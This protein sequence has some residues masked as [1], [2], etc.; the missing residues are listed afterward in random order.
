MAKKFHLGWFMNFSADE[1][2]GVFASGG[3]PFS[4]RFYTEMAQDLERACFDYIMIEDTLMVSDA[5]GGSSELYLRQALMAPKHDPAPLAAVLSAA[6]TRLGVV[7]TL[8]TSFYPPFLLARLATTIDNIAE[9]RF[10]WN[11]VT[12]AEDH[13][14]RN[15]GL[16][17]IPPHARRYD[18]AEEYMEV[19]GKLF[20]SWDADAIVIDRATST[21]ADWTKVN[22][23]NHEGKFFKVRGPLNTAPSPQG[24]P[25]YVQAGGSE[26]GRDF[27]ARHADSV[28]AIALGPEKMREFRADIRARAAAHGRNP[29]DVKVMF[30]ISP[31]L[32]ETDDEARAKQ[33][34]ILNHPNFIEQRLGTLGS[35]TDI[36][37]S[38]FDLDQPLPDDLTTN[39]ETTALEKFLQ[40]GSGKTLR[41]LVIEAGSGSSSVDLVGTP[42]SVADQLAEVAEHVGGDGFLISA[43]GFKVGRRYLAEITDGLV[44]AL[45]RRGL[46]RTEYT[47][48]HLRDTLKEF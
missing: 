26:R 31:I 23:I 41:Q 1:W 38:R 42:E 2:N 37:F 34:R 43:P 16:D 27:A 4:A 21:Y 19:V 44:P 7:A 14:A 40:R 11:I 13:A 9:G 17:Q 15:F 24:R 22:P 47:Q 29:D 3:R 20:A 28:I 39:G 48:S 6:T 45:Q 35:I 46:T 18:I 36:D 33:Q 30:C 25:A 12:S 10:G 5:Y 32:A 8:S